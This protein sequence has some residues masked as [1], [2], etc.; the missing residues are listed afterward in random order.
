MRSRSRRLEPLSAWMFHDPPRAERAR[1]D[2]SPLARVRRVFSG[3]FCGVGLA[4]LA[5]CGRPAT[6]ADCNKVVEKNVEVQLKKM[7]ITD[8]AA[9][10]S[11]KTRIRASLNDTIKG[12]V[13]RKVSDGMM[14]CVD[15]A[16]TVEELDK[17]N[18]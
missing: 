15:N 4:L 14:A 10:E 16:K 9:I 8:P 13:G 18:H 6:E 5:A 2:R 12:C 11:E 7:N 3:V 1:G 17:C